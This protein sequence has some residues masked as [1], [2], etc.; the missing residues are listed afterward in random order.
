MRYQNMDLD[1]GEGEREGRSSHPRPNHHLPLVGNLITTDGKHCW[2]LWET[3]T[4]LASRVWDSG[5]GRLSDQL[6]IP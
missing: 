1:G 3:L 2:E 5:S 4:D 6:L